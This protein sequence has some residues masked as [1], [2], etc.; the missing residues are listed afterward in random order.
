MLS[1][2]PNTCNDS[3]DSWEKNGKGVIFGGGKLRQMLLSF[4]ALPVRCEN[5]R[6]GSQDT[7]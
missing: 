2:L 4:A 7:M 3:W 6:E 5:G 1:W